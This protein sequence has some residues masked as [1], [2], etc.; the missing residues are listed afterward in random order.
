MT[1]FSLVDGLDPDTNLQIDNSVVYKHGGHVL[2]PTP[3]GNDPLSLQKAW[4]FVG[5]GFLV[6]PTDSLTNLIEIRD[7]EDLRRVDSAVK[8][9]DCV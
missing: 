6:N 8:G 1:L 7:E 5:S 4:I 9:V 2:R 3:P